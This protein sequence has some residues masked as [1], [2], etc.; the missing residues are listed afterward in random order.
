MDQLMNLIKFGEANNHEILGNIAV[1]TAS[2]LVVVFFGMLNCN[3]CGSSS[4]AL[5]AT[6]A[7]A[8]KDKVDEPKK[9]ARAPTPS[10][11]RASTPS[12]AAPKAA[13][14]S[15]AKSPV[16]SPKRA[17][18]PAKSPAKSPKRAESP[19]KA[20]AT[21][22]RS[23]TPSKKSTK[24]LAAADREAERAGSLMT[25]DGVRKSSRRL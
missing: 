24:K 9:A 1:I 2:F 10:K 20:K 18:S 12:K 7:P 3:C 8:K 25:P 23:A 6:P 11:S 14:K 17:E 22:K 4:E 16:K 19:A 15:P 5:P 21:P 13:A